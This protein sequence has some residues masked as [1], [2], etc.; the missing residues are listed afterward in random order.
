MLGLQLRG[1]AQV[2]ICIACKCTDVGTGE[3]SQCTWA[4][5]RNYPLEMH[6]ISCL[7]KGRRPLPKG[8]QS[9]ER[10]KLG[11]EST[12]AKPGKTSKR[13]TTQHSKAFLFFSGSQQTYPCST[14]L[15]ILSFISQGSETHPLLKKTACLMPQVG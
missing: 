3:F 14:Y 11:Q 10:F 6:L 4:G 7:P 9:K 15:I 12:E 1:T 8:T 13:R 2:Y 5:G